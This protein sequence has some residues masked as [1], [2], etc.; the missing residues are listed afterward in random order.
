MAVLPGSEQ[1]VIE[2]VA[3]GDQVLYY[4]G[5]RDADKTDFIGYA[6]LTVAR[7]YSSNIRTL[8]GVDTA[9]TVLAI[10]VLYQGETPGLGTRVEEIKS[11]DSSP[12]W[13]DQFKGQPS[14]GLAVDK[15][16]GRI[17]SITGATITSRAITN[18]LSQSVTW[19]REQVAQPAQ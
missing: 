1:G 12:W 9:F 6:L 5:F 3:D 17:Q 7:G 18:G 2:P 19:L 13:Q 4:K 10:K 14:E 11:G 16:G 8:V 15:D